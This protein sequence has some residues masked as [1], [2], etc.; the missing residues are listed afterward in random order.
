MKHHGNLSHHIYMRNRELYKAYRHAIANTKAH[1]SLREV[2]RT[3]ANTPCPRFWVSEERASI[4]ISNIY[5]GQ[6]ILDNMRPRT[7][8]MYMEIF[9]RVDNL[10]TTHPNT[11]LY[12]L[13]FQVVNSPAPKFYL[14]PESVAVIICH[15]KRGRYKMHPT[16]NHGN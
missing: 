15:I 4:V 6:Y 3:V 14:T 1:I 10:R 11:P 9:R 7:R 2:C 13:V 5:K 8:E 12:D 16:Y